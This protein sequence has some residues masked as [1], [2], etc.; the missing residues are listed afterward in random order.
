[1]VKLIP[2]VPDVA[3][4]F[5][6]AATIA[7]LSGPAQASYFVYTYGSTIGTAGD[8]AQAD[9]SVKNGE[10]DILLQN[11]EATTS[12]VGNQISGMVVALASPV[13]TVTLTTAFASDAGGNRNPA[14]LVNFPAGTQS[15]TTGDL[16]HWSTSVSTNTLTLSTFG[17]GGPTGLITGPNYSAGG[18]SGAQSHN[19]NA[20]QYAYFT[21]SALGL[22][23]NE[24]ISAVTFDFGTS[25]EG[26]TGSLLTNTQLV[27]PEPR[28]I[29]LLLT[30]LLG[31]AAVRR[32]R[33]AGRSR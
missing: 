21:M 17:G 25:A 7:F 29:V 16:T 22:T 5:C 4:A 13:G 30:A 2:R 27:V 14:G 8:A 20:I 23:F 6:A 19:P 3:A 15:G 24:L 18:P 31:L 1:M 12:S 28:S 11:T 32:F 26:S 33:R 9:I 10:I